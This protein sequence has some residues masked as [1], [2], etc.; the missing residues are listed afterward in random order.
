LT[1]LPRIDYA[2][3]TTRI[4]SFIVKVVKRASA[5]GVVVGLSG[6]ID[7]AVV[8]ALCVRALGKNRVLGLLLPSDHTPAQDI[9]DATTLAASWGIRAEKIPISRVVDAVTESARIEGTRIARANVEAR[10]RMSILYY[11]AN[12]LGY[13]V[14][15][16]DDRSESLLGYFCYDANTRVVTPDG[17]K[18]IEEL[19]AGDTVFSLEPKS[20][21]MVE[22]KVENV[23]RFP[24]RG[25]LV[26]FKGRGADVMVTPNHKMLVQ[27]SSS[28]PNSPAFFR[29]AEECLRFFRTLVPLPSRW[30][31][32]ENLP[33]AIDLTFVQRHIPRTVRVEIED[34]MYMFGLFIG[35]GAAV[36]LRVVVPVKSDLTR[37]EYASM[38]RDSAGRFMV[39]A[40]DMS[41]PRSKEYDEFETDFAL[42]SYT[43]DKARERLLKIL[44]KYNIGYSLTRD[45]VRIPSKGIYDLFVQCG[46]GAHNKRIPQWLLHYP[47]SYLHWLLRGLKDSD[48]SH[49]ENQNVYYTSSE[50]LK[51]DFVQLCFK[52]GRRASV[53]MRKP[54]TS[55]IKGKT[56]RTGRSY[57]ISFAKRSRFQQAILNEMATKEDYNG[58]VWCPSVPP[59]ENILIEHNGRYLFS[60]NT[61]FGDGGVDF[62]PISHLYKTQVRELG[63]HLGL[64]KTVVNKPASPQLWPGHKA[65][66]EIPAD[67]AKLDIALHNYFDLK[68]SREK[69][70]SKAGLPPSVMDKVL[71][72][73]KRTEHKRSMPPSLA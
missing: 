59:Y 53:G 11:H 48:A 40:Q 67:Y 28:A 22:A 32:R 17:P 25:K 9:K 7:S 64:P 1:G 4:T 41:E 3:E 46:V 57:E 65:S 20:R 24:Y 54:R 45:V 36:K 14:A 19:R 61:K 70:A 29:T 73:H 18:G 51:D 33:L 8:G 63:E 6:G 37:S 47:S 21:D 50:R 27:A 38:P 10:V 66:D 58:E 44:A 72:M 56:V 15:G 71:E 2:K 60:G 12:S 49:A 13:L 69:A 34:L 5:S 16:T 31:G 55:V 52:L 39:L 23:Y 62:L 43:K 35:D 42:P 68:E 30:A 26:H